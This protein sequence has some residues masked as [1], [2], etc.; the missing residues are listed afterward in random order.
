MIFVTVGTHEEPFDRLIAGADRA[1]SE[2]GLITDTFMQVGYSRTR[3]SCAFREFLP[4]AEMQ[5]MIERSDV[6]ISHG[7]PGSILPVLALGKPIVL[8]PRQRKYGEHVDDHQV[9]FCRRLSKT[10]HC[11][12][13][14]DIEHLA[15]A[16]RLATSSAEVPERQA[17]PSQALEALGAAIDAELLKRPTRLT[18]VLPWKLTRHA[19]SPR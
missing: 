8:V 13:V 18:R 11:P 5:R 7:G 12:L 3:P 1:L 10:H 17:N 9:A 15:S 19:Q 14:L 2:V 16:I 6:V 4:F